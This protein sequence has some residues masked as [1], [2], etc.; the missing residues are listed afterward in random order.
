MVRDRS[1]SDLD[2]SEVT[3]DF[4]SAIYEVCYCRAGSLLS[5]IDR[6]KDKQKNVGGRVA[7]VKAL[8]RCLRTC[9]VLIGD[10]LNK[11]LLS[12]KRRG[13]KDRDNCTITV[14]KEELNHLLLN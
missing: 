9:W 11:L 7:K 5:A 14:L 3:S 2:L 10:V 4:A 1:F 6:S 12:N 8:V 13:D